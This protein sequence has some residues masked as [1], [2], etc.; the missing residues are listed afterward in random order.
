M[1]SASLPATTASAARVCG[2]SRARRGAA[3]PR[4]LARCSAPLQGSDGCGRCGNA[5]SRWRSSCGAACGTRQTAACV[6]AVQRRTRFSCWTFGPQSTR[7]ARSRDPSSNPHTL[8][9]LCL[10]QLRV[11]SARGTEDTT[12]SGVPLGAFVSGASRTRLAKRRR[13][14]SGWNYQA[15]G[16]TAQHWVQTK[17]AFLRGSVRLLSAALLSDTEL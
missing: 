9:R 11:V 5:G 10:R 8:S 3:F 12:C 2:G 6:T 7:C 17:G 4:L 16:Q 1:Q 13:R 15:S 14:R